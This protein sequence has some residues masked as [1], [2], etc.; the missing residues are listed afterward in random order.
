M[1]QT[2]DASLN[3]SNPVGLSCAPEVKTKFLQAMGMTFTTITDNAEV[4]VIALSAVIPESNKQKNDATI[5]FIQ[6]KH[7][8]YQKL[9][10]SAKF[11]VKLSGGKDQ[12]LI[13]NKTIIIIKY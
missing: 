7:N 6:I 8:M 13:H 9:L 4:K 1:H 12:F 2:V 3:S 5:F 10:R 11:F